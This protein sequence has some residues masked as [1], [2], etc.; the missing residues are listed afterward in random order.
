M[1]STTG[2]D[3]GDDDRLVATAE[4][5]VNSMTT[6]KS[7]RDEMIRI[8]SGF[9]NRLSI[10]SGGIAGEVVERESE[11]RKGRLEQA[12][13]VI[14]RWEAEDS[15]PWD[16]AEGEEAFEYLAAVDDVLAVMDEVVE[17]DVEVMDKAESLLHTAMA[18]LEDDFR[19]ILI[20]NTVPLDAERLYG[21][22]RKVSLSFAG[23]DGSEIIGD[24]FGSF[25]EDDPD[26]SGYFHERGASLGDNASVELIR[27]DNDAVY[28]LREIA[29]LMIKSGYE[30]ECCQVY[31]SVRRDVLDES[32]AII[33][34]EKVSIDE[35]QKMDWKQ[36]DDKM[37]KWV[38]AVKMVVRLLLFAEKELCC[39]VFD[40]SE[41]I[42]GI[43][44]SEISKGCVMQ[45]L[46][47]GSSVAVSKISSE[48]LFQ[49]LNMYDALSDAIP[50]L[51]E[52]FD[53]ESGYIVRGEAGQ[54][55]K[56]LGEAAKDTLYEFEKQVQNETS[57]KP[58]QGGEIHPLTR[59][60]MNY[61]KLL[62]DYRN[63]LNQLLE[64]DV[65]EESDKNEHG[66]GD[67]KG[68]MSPIG[69][70]LLLLI[71]SLEKNLNEK[72][73]MYEDN[74]LHF[75][76]LMNN[77]RYMVQKVKD[78]ELGNLLGD[79]WIRTRRGLTKQYASNYIRA[80]WIKVLSCLKDVEGSSGSSNKVSK[81]VLKE[82]FKCFNTCFEDLYRTQTGWKIQDP[83]LRDDVRIM[84]SGSVILAYR[85]FLGRFQSQLEGSR[86]S[87]KYLKYSAEELESYLLD[88]FEGIPRDLSNQ[89]RKS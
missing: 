34:V 81:V 58:V 35:V 86:H 7:E 60:V 36:L 51:E 45:L 31:C 76:F 15:L 11:G 77:T 70:R 63:T 74:A 82:R 79:N 61:V 8:L 48:K 12:E 62:V 40:G 13:V 75:I 22:I 46:D 64:H 2:A 47:F 54:V 73:K 84:I 25:G 50:L 30:K 67:D 53:D 6:E 24:E 27:S 65:D 17:G 3:A 68:D 26:N 66:D 88:L 49:I 10:I 42:K 1:T 72:S 80:C 59:Y 43:C 85:A 33:G 20:R 55:L 23:T 14:M 28:H 89:R 4:R 32:L 57:K 29:K 52:L 71:S 37:K 83:Q 38:Q 78:S 44:F 39:E 87:G 41:S 9:D 21:S 18:R 5:I 56:A 16:E 19:L 69:R